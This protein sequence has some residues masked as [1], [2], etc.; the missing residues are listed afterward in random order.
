MIYNNFKMLL[1]LRP[2]INVVQVIMAACML[3][4]IATNGPEQRYK[5]ETSFTGLISRGQMREFCRE[6]CS[7]GFLHSHHPHFL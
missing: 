3:Q 4:S 7:S 2:S 1:H 5:M 6:A